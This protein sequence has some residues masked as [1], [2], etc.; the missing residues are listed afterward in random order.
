M[1]VTLQTIVTSWK[2]N[3]AKITVANGYH[4]TVATVTDWEPRRDDPAVHL[5]AIDI[6]DVSEEITGQSLG[7]DQGGTDAAAEEHTVRFE[8]TL[9]MASTS[10]AIRQFIMDVRKAVRDNMTVTYDIRYLG[11]DATVEQE[12][13]RI[14]GAV[15]RFDVV[16]STALLGEE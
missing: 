5:P 8:I 6:R 4:T 13:K 14:V 15:M 10:T 1:A 9:S 16:Y 3:M 12:E 7:S 11:Y 2:T